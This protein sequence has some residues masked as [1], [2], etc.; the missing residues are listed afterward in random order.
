LKRLDNWNFIKHERAVLDF[1]EEYEKNSRDVS[2]FRATLAPVDDFT[3]DGGV[4]VDTNKVMSHDKGDCFEVF[5]YKRNN[6]N[7]Y[8][9]SRSSKYY[10]KDSPFSFPGGSQG[11]LAFQKNFKIIWRTRFARRFQFTDRHI[12]LINN[13]SLLVSSNSKTELLFYLAL[14]NSPITELILESNLKQENERDYFVPL[15]AVKSFIRIPYINDTNRHIKDE[16]VKCTE[17]IL[18]LEK[19]KLSDLVDFSGILIQKF[20]EVKVVNQTLMLIR[21]DWATKLQVLGSAEVVANAV[22][23]G[24][25]K[26]QN[27]I[28]LAELRNLPVIDFRKQKS[29]KSYIDDLVFALY[30]DIALGIVSLE[31]SDKVRQ[32]CSRSEHYHVLHRVGANSV[33]SES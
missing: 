9:V 24:F 18:D 4:V 8:N 1:Y 14:L 29:L 30:F 6:W 31:N 26:L 17:E 21:G 28:T 23:R 19:V 11:L 27:T 32:A 2:S 33:M 16:I 7:L 20:D 15:R 3:F 22:A 13:Q 5:D 12:L 10:S 25:G